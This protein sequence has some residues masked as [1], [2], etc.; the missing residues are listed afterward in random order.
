M[1]FSM[2]NYL[3]NLLPVADQVQEKP[4]FILDKEDPP[5]SPLLSFIRTI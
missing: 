1:D 4:K 2:S 3:S 5:L